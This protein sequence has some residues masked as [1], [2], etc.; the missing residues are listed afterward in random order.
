[1]TLM[2]LRGRVYDT[3]LHNCESDAIYNHPKHWTKE[4]ALYIKHYITLVVVNCEYVS[5]MR[6]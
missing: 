1:M 2:Y 4:G 3:T 6:C 5:L